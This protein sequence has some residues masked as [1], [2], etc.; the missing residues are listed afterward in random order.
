[1]KMARSTEGDSRID[2]PELSA[3]TMCIMHFGCNLHSQKVFL[4][5][6]LDRHEALFRPVP[7]AKGV[8][9]FNYPAL[10]RRWWCRFWIL[11]FNFPFEFFCE[12][13]KIWCCISCVWYEWMHGREIDRAGFSAG[14]VSHF[15]ECMC[16]FIRWKIYLNA[17]YHV[18]VLVF[19]F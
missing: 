11:C 3:P 2:F 14:F 9:C 7:V 13:C 4:L 10:C 18:N 6:L 17:C 16:N 5:Y 12:W 15:R 19:P 1:M 8:L